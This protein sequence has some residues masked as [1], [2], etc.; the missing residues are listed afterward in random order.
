MAYVHEIKF[1][2]KDDHLYAAL[3]DRPP[4]FSNEFWIKNVRADE[5]GIFQLPE[6]VK[7]EKK[8]KVESLGIKPFKASKPEF[9]FLDGLAKKAW[10][11]GGKLLNLGQLF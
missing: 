10:T 7:L 3:F 6:N 5:I 11:E 1:F 2:F 9:D 4:F 8:Y